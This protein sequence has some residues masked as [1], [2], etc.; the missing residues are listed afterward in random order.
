MSSLVSRSVCVRLIACNKKPPPPGE[1]PFGLRW[2]RRLAAVP[3]SSSVLPP[4]AGNKAEKAIQPKKERAK[5]A[6]ERYVTET[7]VVHG[8]LDAA[9][10]AGDSDGDSAAVLTIEQTQCG[11]RV[12]RPT[13]DP[14]RLCAR[15]LRAVARSRN[16]PD[17]TARNRIVAVEDPFGCQTSCVAGWFGPRRAGIETTAE[18]AVVVLAGM[19]HAARI[20]Q[21]QR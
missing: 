1:G 3:P 14:T 2:S 6:E 9:A 20:I 8:H 11:L 17:P 16:L 7:G 12:K 13:T 18:V 4:G 19:G 10:V 5:N 21:S 15:S